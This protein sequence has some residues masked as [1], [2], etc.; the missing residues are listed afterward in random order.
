MPTT[1]QQLTRDDLLWVEQIFR[2]WGADF[3]VSRGN[4]WYPKDL[5]GFY[6]VDNN[7]K[8]VGLVTYYTN[9]DQC[10]IVTLDAFEKYHGIGTAL[11]KKVIETMKATGKIK[12]LWLITMNDNLDAQRFYYRRGWQLA[13]VHR[14]AMD[15]SRQM[16]PSIPE[17]GAHGIPLRD[18]LEFEYLLADR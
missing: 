6:A 10:E 15:I 13:Q 5:D 16:K 2:Q 14:N 1:I 8:R 7:N 11:L 3:I 9:D 12:R 4:R 18:E 17:I